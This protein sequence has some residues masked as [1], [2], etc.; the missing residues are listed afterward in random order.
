[1]EAVTEDDVIVITGATGTGKTTQVPQFLYEAGFGDPR[2][3]EYPGT[4]VVTQPRRVAVTS[5]AS[6]V[7]D[8]L[9]V[10]LGA[11]VGY[12]IRHTAKMSNK[13]KIRFVTD[14]I[15]LREIEEDLLLRKCSA[16]IVDE[17]HERSI[18]TDLLLTLLS[19]AVLLRRADPDVEPLKV[20]VMSATLSLQG[21]FVGASRTFRDY[22][23]VEI[24][25][26]QHP[27]TVHFS[28]HTAR[29]YLAEAHSKVCKIHRRLPAGGVLVFVT[30][31]AEVETL[32]KKLKESL[33][34]VSV[35]PLYAMLSEKQ[36][37]KVFVASK[38]RKIVVST[39]VAE[40]SIT[41]PDITYVV[42]SGRA[43]ERTYD[44]NGL[45]S[46]FEVKWISKSSAEQRSGRAGRT[47]PG[48]CYRLFSSAVFNHEFDD[49]QEPE[50][51]RA[52]VDTLVLRLYA[53]GIS[54]IMSMP[55]PTKP[56]SA[57]VSQAQ[58]LLG[59]LG[60]VSQGKITALGEELAMLPVSPRLARVLVDATSKGCGP[61][62]CRLVSIMDVGM[63][64][65][66]RIDFTD[67]L[68]KYHCKQSELI[69]Q[70]RVLCH[71][72]QMRSK[73]QRVKQFCTDSNLQLRNVLESLAIATQ[74]E[75]MMGLS[76]NRSQ[77]LT[78]NVAV[79]S[80]EVTVLLKA[81]LYGFP[82]HIARCISRAE[83]SEMGFK[84]GRSFSPLQTTCLEDEVAYVH[85]RIVDDN[86]AEYVCFF[87]LVRFV[88]P[89]SDVN[90]SPG[91]VQVL[92]ASVVERGWIAE[93]AAALCTFGPALCEPAPYYD[94]R[95]ESVCCYV[96]ATYGPGAYSLGTVVVEFTSAISDSKVPMAQY[97][98]FARALLEGKVFPGLFTPTKGVDLSHQ[99]FDGRGFANL[100]SILAAHKIF[101]KDSLSRECRGNRQFLIKE[102]AAVLSKDAASCMQF[103]PF[104]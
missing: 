66:E 38:G 1:M 91:R 97:K 13:T 95:R 83:A 4:V 73:G 23:L 61:L 68:P 18:N 24:P 34:D 33:S 60:A 93:C 51:R 36:Q 41:I 46:S 100:V 104:L 90:S 3:R 16:V 9:N 76:A 74:L 75:Q 21:I 39:N 15:I 57:S 14:G 87:E 35:L 94:T 50:I 99:R 43:K 98:V 45:L 81:L 77:V 10:E 11:E 12:Q 28:R 27:V 53:M 44:T 101:S 65:Q 2:S 96:K 42:D 17:A 72:E 49:E 52:P 103:W 86:D 84:V 31:R 40:T 64:T 47:R 55:L 54:D 22:R 5:C 6:R 62:A 69:G 37:H 48:H 30:G 63:L 89:A 8:E 82:D 26:R 67:K 88:R 85:S 29:D 78:E 102:V 92:G 71:I 32:C 80:A 59:Y 19:K 25:S 56:E 58:A 20:I 7:A 70:L 79:T